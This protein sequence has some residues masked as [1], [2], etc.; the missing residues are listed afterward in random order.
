MSWKKTSVVITMGND[1]YPKGMKATTFNNIVED[2]TK[3]QI[4]LFAQGLQLL[5]DG[6]VFLG[7]EIIKHDELGAE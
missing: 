4:S 1:K 3:E 2:P 7:S 5:S 6:D